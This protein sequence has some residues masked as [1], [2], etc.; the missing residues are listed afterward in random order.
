VRWAAVAIVSAF[1]L[2]AWVGNGL[3]RLQPPHAAPAR[4][5]PQPRTPSLPRVEPAAA[6]A[7]FQCDGRRYCSEMRSCEEAMF[8]LRNCPDTRMDGDGDGIPCEDQWCG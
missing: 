3:D 2:W 6:P 5:M 8:F 1:A 4:A 7:S